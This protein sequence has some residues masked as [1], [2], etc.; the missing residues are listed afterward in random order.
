M[1]TNSLGGPILRWKIISPQISLEAN[2]ERLLPEEWKARRLWAQLNHL[3]SQ[4]IY[5]SF[6]VVCFSCDSLCFY[7]LP[8][9]SR[10]K[11][12]CCI[13][14]LTIT[15]IITIHRSI[16]LKKQYLRSVNLQIPPS[17]DSSAEW[18]WNDNWFFFFHLCLSSNVLKDGS[19]PK[20]TRWNLWLSR[21]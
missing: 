2:V 13:S 8:N 16:F 6:W 9:S 17:N 5:N 21:N 7:S 10:I 19:W 18:H 12:R 4:V 14:L 1:V 20:A 3:S 11:I 15:S